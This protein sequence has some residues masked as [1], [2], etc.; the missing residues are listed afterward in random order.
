MSFLGYFEA[1]CVEVGPLLY[2]YAFK[3]EGEDSFQYELYLLIQGF[4][5]QIL[6]DIEF[7]ICSFN[8]LL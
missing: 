8:F 5:G 6:L 1:E 2:F 4:F 7:N 3:G